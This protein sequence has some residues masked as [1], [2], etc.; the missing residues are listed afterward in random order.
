MLKQNATTPSTMVCDL[1]YIF[2]FVRYVVVT[3]KPWC[4]RPG[5]LQVLALASGLKHCEHSEHSGPLWPME[6]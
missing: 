5:V 3:L 1:A 4:K 2:H 6:V